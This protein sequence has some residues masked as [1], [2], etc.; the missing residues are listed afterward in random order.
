MAELTFA[1]L[2]E[3]LNYDF[4]T[5]KLFWR[6]RERR[7]FKSNAAHASFNARFANKEAFHHSHPVNKY[8]TGYI[9]NESHKA[10]HLIW[11]MCFGYWPKKQIDHIDGDRTNNRITNLRE[12]TLAENLKNQSIYSNNTSGMQGVTFKKKLNKWAV[13]ANNNGKRLHLGYYENFDD[14]IRVRKQ[15]EIDYGYHPNHGRSK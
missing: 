14:A 15:A 13:R 9:L 1:D 12:V 7:W 3:L 11:T 5:G 2:W 8:K 4:E 6:Y 10:H